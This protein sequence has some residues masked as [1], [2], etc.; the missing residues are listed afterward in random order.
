M[1]DEYGFECPDFDE[2]GSCI[3]SDHMAAAGL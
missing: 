1:E 3:H 2:D